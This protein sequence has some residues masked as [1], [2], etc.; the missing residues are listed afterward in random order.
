MFSK[1]ILSPGG[2]TGA[3][4]LVSSTDTRLFSVA[5]PGLGLFLIAQSPGAD[6]PRYTLPPLRGSGRR[7]PGM[8]IPMV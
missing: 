7:H 8:V 6:A 4:V 2:A 5:P 3:C 1:K